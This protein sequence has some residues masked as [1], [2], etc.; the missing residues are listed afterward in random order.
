M[1]LKN[2][3]NAVVVGMGY[4]GFPLACILGRSGYSVTGIDV[5][6]E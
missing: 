4:V 5:N 1:K 3:D 2:K 6:E